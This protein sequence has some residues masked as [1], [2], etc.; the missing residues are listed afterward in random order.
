ME[1]QPARNA[2]PILDHLE[3]M[4]RRTAGLGRTTRIQGIGLQYWTNRINAVINEINLVSCQKLRADLLLIELRSFNRAWSPRR[5]GSNRVR[6]VFC[7][8]LRRKLAEVRVTAGRP[9]QSQMFSVA[10]FIAE[11]K[12]AA[13]LAAQVRGCVLT[14]SPV[15]AE[16]AVSGDRGIGPV[17]EWRRK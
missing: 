11:V 2:D 13:D 10:E 9:V 12:Y 14:V 5:I 7:S 4:I 15:D 6:V 8:L 17:P 3:E 16:L 1:L